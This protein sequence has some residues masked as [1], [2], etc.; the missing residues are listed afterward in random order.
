MQGFNLGFGVG[1]ILSAINRFY[2]QVTLLFSETLL[3]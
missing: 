1:D 3:Q 2:L